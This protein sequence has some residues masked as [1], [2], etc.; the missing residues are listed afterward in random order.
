MV[1]RSAPASTPVEI[2]KA[3]DKGRDYL[4]S[5]Q[6]HGNWELVQTPNLAD[7]NNP[8]PNNM[9]FGGMTAIAT[10][11]LLAAGESPQNPKLK[12]SINWLKHAK[13]KG[14]YAISLR[15]QV[16]NMV[17]QDAS[18][19]EAMTLDRNLLLQAVCTKGNS[20]GFYGYGVN[21]PKDQ[22]DKSVSQF[23]V[24]G[25]WALNQAGTEI[26]SN[27]WRL[28]EDHWRMQQMDGG[29]WCYDTTRYP[30]LS[31][32]LPT[33]SMTA[34]GVA[35][36]FI[37]QDFTSMVP[38]TNGNVDDR[39]IDG[40]MKWL[41]AH[42]N[43]IQ[44]AR[45][46]YS[47]FG[48]SRVGL[49][50][51]YKYIGNTDWFKWGADLIVK[52]QSREGFWSDGFDNFNNVPETGLALLFL[53]RGRAPVMMNKLQYDVVI[54]KN[55]V[56]GTWNERPRDV[57]NLTHMVGKN[58]EAE[59][60]WQIVNLHQ[61]FKD[62]H[63]APLLYMA[64]NTAPKLSPEDQ[65]HLRAYIEDGGIVVGHA[66]ASSSQFSEGFRKLGET[67]FP[68]PGRR[69]T[70][71]PDTHPIY[72]EQGFPRT[73]WRNK[74][75]VQAITNGD[76][77]LMLL[78]PSGD[79][80]QVWQ[81]QSFP[82][83]KQDPFGQLMID[84][85]LYAEDQQGLREKGSTYIVTRND[86]I[87]AD[88]T[89]KLARLKYAGNWD[90]E[91]GGWRRL[92]NAMHNDRHID[93]D[94]HIVDLTRDKLDGTFQAAELTVGGP[95]AL[96][97]PE[98][99]AI[100]D[101]VSKGGTLVFDVAGGTSQSRSAAEG[102]LEKL[103]PESASKEIS[104]LPATSPVYH[105][106]LDITEVTYRHSSRAALGNLHVPRLRGIVQGNRVGV[107]YSPEDLVA[108]LVGQQVGGIIGYAP[109]SATPL[110]ENI[111]TYAAK[112]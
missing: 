106:G 60:S 4:Y 81:S 94:A 111:L 15:A 97:D 39:W 105:A 23:G 67:M 59:Q 53:S 10:F 101:Y 80:A 83:I 25:L 56:P 5:R 20:L 82:P 96:S 79:P 68:F 54:G 73:G 19:R 91:P 16:W 104:L 40:G 62:L 51:G 99:A 34:A 36:L 18:V 42:F 38:R 48:I 90:P 71:L 57:A 78:L 7:P 9:Q 8:S 100:R 64:G 72:T 52:N 50:A 31:T 1:V 41:G 45:L 63:D 26:P 35:T 22:S 49:A 110:M 3:I 109:E 55:S 46:Y 88:S 44:P 102:E 75:I 65:D 112:H 43:D 69:F 76:R 11:A 58:V 21:T 33:V 27:S 77:V 61:G 13:M 28:F 93:L 95:I 108:G 32:S 6:Q 89:I 14:V 37:T 70:A 87:H 47:M 24:L 107:I 66:D 29:G 17:P 98:R 2:Q 84:I 86:A 30:N 74:P 85:V 12:E 103:F 92:A